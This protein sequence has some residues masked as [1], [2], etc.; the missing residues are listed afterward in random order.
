[1]DMDSKLEWIIGIGVTVLSIAIPTGIYTAAVV[2]EG[3]YKDRAVAYCR[4]NVKGITSEGYGAYSF[5]RC[6][7]VLNDDSPVPDMR[8]EIIFNN[9]MGN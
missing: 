8:N 2:Q 1:M 6:S 3:N 4:E 7:D 5:R 9:G